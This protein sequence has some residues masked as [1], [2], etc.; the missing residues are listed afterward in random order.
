MQFKDFSIVDFPL[1]KG[2]L[3][4]SPQ[5][6]VY[7]FCWVADGVEIPFYVGQ[8]DRFSLR[9]KDYCLAS[10]SACTDFCVGEA[11]KYLTS[12]KNKR[13]VVR[14][15]PSLEPP[16]EEKAIIRELL[17]SGVRLL[18]CLPRYDYRT[19][20]A[21]EERDAIRRFC[22]MLMGNHKGATNGN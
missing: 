7:V 4:G 5:G 14:Y 6:F 16:K 18:N 1:T 19:A 3:L 22:D 8:T 2:A 10:F 9:M 13:V 15:R 11:V 12:T 21:M 20:T 17:I